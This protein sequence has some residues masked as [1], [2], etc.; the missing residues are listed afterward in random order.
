M[1]LQ[2]ANNDQHTLCVHAHI[3]QQGESEKPF[4]IGADLAEGQENHR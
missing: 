3:D 4:K 1:P 2:V